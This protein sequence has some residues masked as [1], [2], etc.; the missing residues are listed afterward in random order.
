MSILDQFPEEIREIILNPR[1]PLRSITR[2]DLMVI[3]EAEAAGWEVGFGLSLTDWPGGD[4]F[5]DARF[6]RGNVCVWRAG[7]HYTKATVL[8]GFPFMDNHEH[9]L[10]LRDALGLPPEPGSISR[11][12]FDAHMAQFRGRIAKP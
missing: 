3:P 1:H 4:F 2:P 8:T 9:D 7:L 10:W 11:A 6:R 12:E 5:Q